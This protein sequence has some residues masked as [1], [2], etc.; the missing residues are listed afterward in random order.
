[1][2]RKSLSREI[3]TVNLRLN[4]RQMQFQLTS[5]QSKVAIQKLNPYLIIGIGL[6]AGVVTNEMGWRKVYAFAGAGFSFY[7][8]LISRFSPDENV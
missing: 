3:E 2:T 4:S 8:F 5:D 7:P 6:L 1:M